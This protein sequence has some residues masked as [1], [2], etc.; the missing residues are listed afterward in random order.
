MKKRKPIKEKIIT[1][2]VTAAEW[3]A[4]GDV[5]SI[6]IETDDGEYMVENNK[7]SQE[8]YELL[9]DEVEVTGIIKKGKDGTNWI[10][11]M[12]YEPLDHAI[13]DVDNMNEEELS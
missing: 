10:R 4:S 12:D 6:C 9:D 3:H 2:Y 8:L 5:I 13:Y 11:V 1:G 7:I